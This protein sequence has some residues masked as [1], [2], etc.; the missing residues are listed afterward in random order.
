MAGNPI[1]MNTG[2]YYSHELNMIVDYLDENGTIEDVFRIKT[3]SARAG[4]VNPNTR[5]LAFVAADMPLHIE[6]MRNFGARLMHELP[7][8]AGT[9]TAVVTRGSGTTAGTMKVSKDVAENQSVQVFSTLHR[10]L[11][12]LDASL[13]EIETAFPNLKRLFEKFSD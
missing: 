3:D 11:G 2:T 9:R 5:V 12:F 7:E 8:Y 4:Y 1:Q 10:A 6:E 13:Q